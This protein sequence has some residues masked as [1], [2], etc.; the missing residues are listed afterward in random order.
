MKT[1]RDYIQETEHWADQPAQGDEF[2]IELAPDHLIESYVVGVEDDAVIIE[3]DDAV[4]SLLEQ[5]GAT[6][7]TI[8]RYG[9]V[10][11]SPGMGRSILEKDEEEIEEHGGG[12]GPKQHWQDLMPKNEGAMK[13]LDIELQDYQRMTPQ[14]FR[15]AYGMHKAD[16]ALKH[17]DLLQKHNLQVDFTGK[18]GFDYVKETSDYMSRILELAGCARKMEEDQ[19][20]DIVAKKELDIDAARDLGDQIDEREHEVDCYEDGVDPVNQYGQDSEEMT[21]AMTAEGDM[22]EAKYQGREVQLGKPFLTPGGPKKRAVYVR[23]PK[24]NIVKVSF[25]DPN[26]RIKKSNPARRKSFR[27]RHRC[28]NPGP[29]HKARYWSCRAW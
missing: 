24:G 21:G 19:A 18:T 26:M 3:G 16:W 7:E 15:S 4:M 25:G 12:I 1:L 6:L 11:S 23:N 2:D 13:D 8:G 29:R 9:A 20:A 10:G 14:Q 5:H 27:A 17:M 28:D 22:D